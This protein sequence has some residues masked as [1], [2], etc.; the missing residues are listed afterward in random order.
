LTFG[1][2]NE[3]IVPYN[4]A[5]NNPVYFLDPDG[6]Q[7]DDWVSYVG[8]KWATNLVIYDAG[9]KSNKQKQNIKMLQMFFKSGS[10]AG[11]A[12]TGIVI[13]HIN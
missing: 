6:T 1:G 12:Q 2:T 5:F 3:D 13:I 11:T 8:K 7:A 4:Y 10:I 9:V